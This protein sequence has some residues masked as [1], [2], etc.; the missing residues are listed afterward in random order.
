MNEQRGTH[1]S[2]QREIIE[3]SARWRLIS[4][5]FE[6][7]GEGWLERLAALATV[8]PDA[9]LK[10]ASIAAQTEASESLYHSFFGP[11]GPASP[12]EASYHRGVELGSLMSELTGYY[13]AFGY[14]PATQEALDHVSVEAGFVGYLR[15]KEAYAQACQDPDHA[16]TSADA[17]KSFVNR[18]LSAIAQPLAA[19]LDRS[20]I[21]Y[22]SLAGKALVQNT[23]R[24][25]G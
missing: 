6:P 25:K 18:H 17:T 12:R 15:M 3:D 20:G 2:R 11:G 14:D 22:L 5:L 4:L 16:E 10:S 8:I 13:Q 19:A 9:D 24:L 23:Q 7:P 21:Q 1:R